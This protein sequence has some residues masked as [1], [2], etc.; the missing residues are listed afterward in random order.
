MS[1]LPWLLAACAGH[2]PQRPAPPAAAPVDSFL[3][4]DY[5]AELFVDLAAMRESGLLD[6]LLRLP[7]CEVYAEAA[8]AAYGTDVD[9]LDRLRSARVAIEVV[10]G[11]GI[12]RSISVA[13]GRFASDAVRQA[14]WQPLTIGSYRGWVDERDEVV[15][16]PRS[17]KAV[18]GDRGQLQAMVDGATPRG[19]PHPDLQPLLGGDGVLAQYAFGCFGR[20]VSAMMGSVGF[21]TSWIDETDPIDVLRLRLAATPADELVLS[22]TARFRRGTS[23][24]ARIEQAIAGWLAETAGDHQLA[25]L[26]TVL[27][28]LDLQRAQ[29]DLTVSL[30]L[31]TP[32]Q[33]VGRIER[34][35]LLLARARRQGG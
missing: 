16:W 14:P 21:P 23:G 10:S 25:P 8:A 13:E 1:A 22:A 17:G 20:P 24:P 2:Q 12:A 30:R 9:G 7:T 33:A 11:R 6:L 15:F 3:P 5:Q 19:G 32:R 18:L 26:R 28:G 35:A 4:A 34:A 27:A 31:G 29:R